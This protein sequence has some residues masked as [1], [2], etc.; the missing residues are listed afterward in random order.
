MLHMHGI[1]PYTIYYW[2]NTVVH[3]ILLKSSIHALN[4]ITYSVATDLIILAIKHFQGLGEQGDQM[5]K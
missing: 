2:A 3:L 4:I 1:T 5:F